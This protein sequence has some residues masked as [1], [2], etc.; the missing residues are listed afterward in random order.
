MYRQ[1][2]SG[3]KRSEAKKVLQNNVISD[4]A[5]HRRKELT[6]F[7]VASDETGFHAQIQTTVRRGFDRLSVSSRAR[8]RGTGMLL[9]V[10]CEPTAYWRRFLFQVFSS[11]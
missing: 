3:L 5:L 7:P 4:D 10:F 2:V 9:F 8:K 11:T 6:E 1:Q